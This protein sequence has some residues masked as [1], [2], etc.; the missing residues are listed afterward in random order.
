[1]ELTDE[2]LMALPKFVKPLINHVLDL[3][4]SVPWMKRTARLIREFASALVERDALLK[5]LE[6]AEELAEALEA[7]VASGQLTPVSICD[8][9]DQALAAWRAAGE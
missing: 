3:G 4:T 1:M 8:R 6:A 9:I 7:F 5:R 2:Q